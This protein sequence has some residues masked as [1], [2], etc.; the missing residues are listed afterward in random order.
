MKKVK[1]INL[2]NLY[3]TDFALHDIKATRQMWTEGS[4]FNMSS[5]RSYNAFILL[6]N[7]IGTYAGNGFSFVAQ[8]GVVCLPYGSEYT[9]HNHTCTHTKQD[10]I[11][12]N[13]NLVINGELYTISKTPFYMQ[14][15]NFAVAKPLFS[16][17]VDR[18]ENSAFSPMAFKSAMWQLLT[19]LCKESERTYLK[20]YQPIARGIELL[21]TNPM[22]D[23][24]IAQIASLCNVSEGYFRRLFHEYKGEAP[25]EFRLRLRLEL[26]KRLLED[27]SVTNEYIAEIA[28]FESATYFC[29]IFKRKF[30][31]S[32]GEYRERKLL[33]K[34]GT[35]C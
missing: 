32:P 8:K 4:I 5:P 21:E 35:S 19:Y 14:E 29:R 16:E 28:G 3:Y 24:S 18:F 2:R 9:C 17:V 23:M 20:K 25:A 1:E 15:I 31:M 7:C 33:R 22:A 10:A 13:F 34:A 26:A 6:D 30:G 12:V 11:L 27:D